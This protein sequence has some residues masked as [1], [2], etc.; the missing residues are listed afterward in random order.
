[1]SAT[2]TPPAVG[3]ML[4]LSEYAYHTDQ[5]DPD[6][7]SLSR[8]VIQT[9]IQKTPAHARAA[10]PKLNPMWERETK[11]AFDVG[12]VCHQLLLDGAAGVQVIAYDSWRTNAA[13]DAAAEARAHGLI[14]LLEKDWEQVDAMMTALRAQLEQ[15]GDG[16]FTGGEHEVTLAWE[17]RGVLCRA[18]LDYLTDREIHDFKTSSNPEPAKFSRSSFFDYGYDLQD[19]FYRRGVKACLGDDREFKLAV[20]E[21]TAPYSLIV[22]ESS[23]DTLELA[24][25]KID[26]AL[27]VW[28]RCLAEDSWPGYSTR[29]HS[30]TLP[31]WAE[32][33]WFD[34]E[35]R[36]EVA[37]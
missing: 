13:K 17:E 6:R 7:P 16:L 14:P 27:V 37:A 2:D 30:V 8:S 25:R 29:T 11:P 5:V 9:L 3:Q 21:K 18:R 31:P 32:P 28:A 20:V 1:M 26:W 36:E 34:R 19:A 4:Q 10:H 22:F 35:A 23:P 33:Q 24:N 12:T 15:R